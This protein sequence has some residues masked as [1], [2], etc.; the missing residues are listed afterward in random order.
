MPPQPPVTAAEL[1]TAT[2]GELMGDGAAAVHAIAPLDRAGAGDL[3]FLAS[4][5]YAPMMADSRAGIVL[6]SPELKDVPGQCLARVVVADPQAALLSLMPRFYRPAVHPPGIHPAAR[7][8]QNVQLGEDVCIEALAVVEDDAVIGD[9]TWI[10]THTVIG[11]GARVGDDC[12]VYPNVTLYP[13]TQVGHRVILH[14]GARLGSD[15]YGYVQQEVDGRMAHVK[16]PHLGRAI[17]GND[18]EIGANAT[19]DRG[20]VDDTV[21]GDGTKIDNLAQ[22]GHNVRIGKLC[23]IMA[24][25]G[26]AGSVRIEDGVLIAGQAAVTGH[27]TIGAGARLAGQS[28][29]ISD[30]PA[31]E[32]WSG[33][34]ARPHKESLRASAALLRLPALLRRIEKLLARAKL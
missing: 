30:V 26:I 4:A 31:G 6:V 17:I 24:Q 10:A 32:T 27:V 12:L 11:A 28:G 7:I 23:L 29:A 8:G 5:H 16:I 18:V 14:S 19:I 34:P 20:S 33:Y 1:A 2:G 22:V 13:H 3:S 9:R 21:I 25:V 15:G